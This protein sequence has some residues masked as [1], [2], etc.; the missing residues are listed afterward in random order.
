MDEEVPSDFEIL[1]PLLNGNNL[2][3]WQMKGA[4]THDEV[5]G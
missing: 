2:L 1:P 5:F 3:M 4:A